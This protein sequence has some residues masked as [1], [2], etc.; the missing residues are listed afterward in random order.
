MKSLWNDF[1]EAFNNAN[2]IIVTD[3]YAASEDPIEGISGGKF[4][5]ELN[6]AEYI[7]GSIEE[8]GEKLYPT[9]NKGN[10]VIGLGAGTITNLGKAIKKASEGA[11]CK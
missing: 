2:R 11:F 9:L 3:I 8:V 6:G 1:K 7:S 5:S 4:A 10:I